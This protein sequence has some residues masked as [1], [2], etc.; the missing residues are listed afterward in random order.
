MNP[1]EAPP[2]VRNN[3]RE[4]Q[5]LLTYLEESEAKRADD[6]PPHIE[7][8]LQLGIASA[9]ARLKRI[10]GELIG[11]LI[12][13]YDDDD[14]VMAQYDAFIADGGDVSD[15]NHGMKLVAKHKKIRD[16]ASGEHERQQQQRQEQWNALSKTEQR[17]E[18][19]R[20]RRIREEQGEPQHHGELHQHGPIHRNPG[21]RKFNAG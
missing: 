1:N 5:S 6:L 12:A 9:H 18:L 21:S 15:V 7:E 16:I 17:E 19:D 13:Y 2:E 3:L 20:Q 4:M 10:K 11:I 14:E 8:P